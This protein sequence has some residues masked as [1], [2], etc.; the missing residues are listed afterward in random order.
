[1]K[2]P[3]IIASATAAGKT[4]FAFEILPPLK[5]DGTEAIYASIDE[6]LP[7]DPA[8][9]NITCHRETLRQVVR[10]DGSAD[11]HKERRLS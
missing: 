11:I 3:Q 10:P 1:M 8:Y 6:L 9:I 2:V 4:R 7:F 5:G